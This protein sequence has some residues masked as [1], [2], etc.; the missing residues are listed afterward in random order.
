MFLKLEKDDHEKFCKQTNG[1]HST[2]AGSSTFQYPIIILFENSQV[3][4]RIVQIVLRDSTFP[5]QTFFFE[6]IFLEKFQ[7]FWK[8]M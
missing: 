5:W 1:Y 2:M 4:N 7:H 8:I 6:K 3:K